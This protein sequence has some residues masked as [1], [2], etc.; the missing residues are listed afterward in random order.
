ML[1]RGIGVFAVGFVLAGFVQAQFNESIV[2]NLVWRNVG[3][4]AAGGRITSLAVAGDFRVTIYIG[5][6]AGGVFK[7]TNNAVTWEP[8]FDH[9]STSSIGAI[10]V[11]AAN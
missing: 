5:T 1:K 2:K 11:D 6:H 3:P 8:V 4:A 7:T 9:E 10:A